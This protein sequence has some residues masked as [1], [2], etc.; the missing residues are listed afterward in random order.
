MCDWSSPLIIFAI[1]IRRSFRFDQRRGID[2][3]LNNEAPFVVL[4]SCASQ[5]SFS[6]LPSQ[7]TRS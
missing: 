2:G 6:Q 5:G 4:I 7:E 3:F 1:L